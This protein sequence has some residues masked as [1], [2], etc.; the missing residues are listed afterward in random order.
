MVGARDELARRTVRRQRLISAEC[1]CKRLLV[2]AEDNKGIIVP[3]D[4]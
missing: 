4:P 1:G 3:S 2:S